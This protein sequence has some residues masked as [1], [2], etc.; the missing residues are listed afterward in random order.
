MHPS[1]TKIQTW[2]WN[3]QGS[4]RFGDKLTTCTMHKKNIQ[5]YYSFTKKSVQISSSHSKMKVSKM[6]PHLISGESQLDYH[7]IQV[8]DIC[9]TAAFVFSCYS[10]FFSFY[11]PF[12]PFELTNVQLLQS[13][14][15]IQTLIVTMQH[16]GSKNEKYF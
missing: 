12:L 11:H 13:T 16:I 3:L 10:Y 2:I 9:N 7:S 1:P 5:N 15:I 6:K 14:R 8:K 4:S